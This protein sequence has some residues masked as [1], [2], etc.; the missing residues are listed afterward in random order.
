MSGGAARV[1]VFRFCHQNSLTPRALVLLLSDWYS[2]M[3]QTDSW[4]T[5]VDLANFDFGLVDQKAVLNRNFRTENL[6]NFCSGKGF[7]GM[8]HHQYLL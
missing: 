2:N 3:A 1:T 4:C 7:L 5:Q 8:G 6:K